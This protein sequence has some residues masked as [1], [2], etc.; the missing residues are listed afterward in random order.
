MLAATLQ[1]PPERPTALVIERARD[2]A[3]PLAEALHREAFCTVSLGAIADLRFVL[4]RHRA[5]V[6][7]LDFAACG[8]A[9]SVLLDEL[10]AAPMAPVTVL[11]AAEREGRLL[12]ARYQI[13]WL[14]EHAPASALA[15]VVSRAR[16][17]QRRARPRRAEAS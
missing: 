9:L 8:E 12:A 2:G 14:R 3:R 11:V 4:R 15:D 10:A 17:Q 16:L 1:A 13:A 7:V 6:L 5:S